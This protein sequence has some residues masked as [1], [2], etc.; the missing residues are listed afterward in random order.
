MLRTAFT[1]TILR[2]ICSV[3][4]SAT[5]LVC[6]GVCK[7]ETLSIETMM[8]FDYGVTGIRADAGNNVVITGG[9]GPPN[10]RQGPPAFI[11][12]GPL[13]AVTSVATISNPTLHLF[14]PT[15]GGNTV[16]GAMFYGPNTHRFNPTAIPDGNVRAVGTYLENGPDD[17][18]KGMIYDGPLD[19]TGAW[20]SLH[21]PGAD[22]AATI[23]HSTMG[24][25][26]VGNYNL[27]TSVSVGRPFV[28]DIDSP[29][30]TRLD[31]N[32]AEAATIYGIWQNGGELSTSYTIIGGLVQ[33]ASSTSQGFIASYDA[34]SQG[35]TGLALYSFAGDVAVATHFEGISAYN[36]GF[37]IAANAVSG[38]VSSPAYAFIPYTGSVGS[39]VYGQA[40]WTAVVNTINGTSATGDTVIDDRV[41]GIYSVGDGARSYITSVPE[42]DPSCIGSALALLL[43]SLG[44]LERR[45]MKTA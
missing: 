32:G 25:L 16:Y 9:I 28:Y 2:T 43:G 34:I 17:F 40:T 41:M 27:F 14:R 6:A 19:G 44:F 39:Y 13:D 38:G 29:S 7:A 8:P 1:L 36:G 22:I 4:V 30:Y 26:V 12:K 31:I 24:N 3:T 18:Q 33:T 10:L 21:V 35:V 5:A 37:S 15:F 11:Y 45:Q 42:I 20:T 23:P